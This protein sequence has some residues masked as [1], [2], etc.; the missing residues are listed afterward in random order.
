MA[1]YI[2][3]FTDVSPNGETSKLY[4]VTCLSAILLNETDSDGNIVVKATTLETMLKQICSKI[5]TLE[6]KVSQL[7][8]GGSTTSNGLT[9]FVDDNNILNVQYDDEE[10]L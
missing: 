1:D 8:G 2:E 6:K 7:S 9:F 4:P 5:N 3:Q 10:E